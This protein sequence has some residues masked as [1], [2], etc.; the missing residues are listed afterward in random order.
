MGYPSQGM[1]L[2]DYQE[3]AMQTAQVPEE[4]T[5]SGLPVYYAM[6]LAGEAGE[7]LD[8]IKK[9]WRNQKPLDREAALRELGDVLWYIAA[10]AHQLGATLE[11]VARMNIAKLRDRKQ[12]GVIRSEGDDR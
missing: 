4:C 6:G 7:Y 3:R 11:D 9:A 8:K 5:P 10:N 12:R 2:D 1:T